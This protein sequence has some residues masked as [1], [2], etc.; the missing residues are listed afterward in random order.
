MH[1]FIAI[2]PEVWQGNPY[3]QPS[4]VWALAATLLHWIKPAMLG[5]S[6]SP[7]PDVIEPWSL[8]KLMRLFPDWKG[9]PV[10][11]ERL[12]RRFEDAQTLTTTARRVMFS[13]WEEEKQGMGL[14]T[15]VLDLLDRMLVVDPNQRP[16][17]AEL[18]ESDE[19]RRVMECVRKD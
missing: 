8:A 15:E 17:A 10:D 12:R 9:P 13:S 4:Q 2:A 19:F 16:S 5:L 11:D 14:R 7:S 6:G 1:G 18:L 3:G